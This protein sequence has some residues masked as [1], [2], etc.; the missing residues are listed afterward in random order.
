MTGNRGAVSSEP[1]MVERGNR[2]RRLLRCAIG[3]G[4]HEVLGPAV[5]L[6]QQDEALA[7]VEEQCCLGAHNQR[8]PLER[9]QAPDHRREGQ[10]LVAADL[11]HRASESLGL[12]SGVALE[13]LGEILQPV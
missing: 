8:L 6:D 5:A 4:D 2:E 1:V 13:G 11:P 3:H 12:A 7:L 10:R 9:A